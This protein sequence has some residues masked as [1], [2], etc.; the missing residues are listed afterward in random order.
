MDHMW[1]TSIRLLG[2]MNSNPDMSSKLGLKDRSYI[3]KEMI[4]ERRDKKC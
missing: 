3:R 1:R 2:K 4:R